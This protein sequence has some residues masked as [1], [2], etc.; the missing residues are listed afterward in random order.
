MQSDANIINQLR[1]RR[2]IPLDG[3]HAAPAIPPEPARPDD[4]SARLIKLIPAEVVATFVTIDGILRSSST[5]PP[6]LVFWLI[7]VALIFGTYAHTLWVGKLP[8]LPKPHL[9]ASL[10]TVSFIVWVYALGGPF[11]TLPAP[12][13]APLYGS[14]L[15]PLYVFFIPIVISRANA[16]QRVS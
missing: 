6:E 16:A 3:R 13:Y 4:Y 10:A 5:K 1:V 11:V 9:Q 7:F 12:W 8:P 2:T 15:L 14:I